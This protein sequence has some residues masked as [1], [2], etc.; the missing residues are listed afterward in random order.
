M[1]KHFEN[2]K[3][4][5]SYYFNLCQVRKSK[6][7]PL[8]PFRMFCAFLNILTQAIDVKKDNWFSKYAEKTLPRASLGERYKQKRTGNAK[9]WTGFHSFSFAK[10]KFLSLC[11]IPAPET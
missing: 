2:Y 6:T 10:L 3:H 5:V 8:T 7:T 9:L 1:K 4:K 11:P